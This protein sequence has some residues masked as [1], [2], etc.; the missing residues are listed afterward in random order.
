MSSI[1]IHDKNIIQAVA[2][3]CDYH[4]RFKST[5]RHGNT[6]IATLAFFRADMFLNKS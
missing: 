3:T 1:R 2:L 4:G 6:K 5:G